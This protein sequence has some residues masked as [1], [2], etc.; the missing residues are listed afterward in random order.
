MSEELEPGIDPAPAAEVTDP[1]PVETGE[2]PAAEVTDPTPVETGESTAAAPKNKGLGKRIDELTREKYEARRDSDY[3]REMAMRQQQA[4]Q[5]QQAEPVA[6]D[7][8]PKEDDFNGDWS[9]YVVAA[10]K[11]EA[12]QEIKREQAAIT[13]RQQAEQRQRAERDQ[14]SR[15]SAMIQ[16]GKASFEDFESVTMR[17]DVLITEAMIAAATESDT[18]HAVLYH[19]AKNPHE[20][21]RIA[22]LSPIAQVREIGRL[23]AKIASVQKTPTQAPAP[24]K[25][26]GGNEPTNN[27]PDSSKDPDAW[28]A[29]ERERVKKLGRRY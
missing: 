22:S 26:V 16:K 15:T 1:A 29:Y 21:A 7:K 11:Y 10:A 17:P 28:L 12:R 18:G 19:L 3:W 6:E 14:K 25:P 2:S 23:E 9:A 27:E 24:I 5:P 8:P 20:S 4:P 13:A